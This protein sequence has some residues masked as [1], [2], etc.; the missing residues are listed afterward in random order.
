MSLFD[1]SSAWFFN[2]FGGVLGIIAGALVAAVF[3]L[4]IYLAWA[5]VNA[6]RVLVLILAK[7]LQRYAL[8]DEVV[9]EYYDAALHE[10][11]REFHN[12]IPH[13]VRVAR[14][15]EYV[16]FKHRGFLKNAG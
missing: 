10:N 14:R 1:S 2:M 16:P 5:F 12:P 9:V 15:G 4:I 7:A 3:G 11:V 13:R 6:L 8:R